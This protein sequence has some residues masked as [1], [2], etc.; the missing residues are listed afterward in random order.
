MAGSAGAEDPSTRV[1]VSSG[2]GV[3]VGDR[4]TQHNKYIHTNIETVVIQ[5]SL[6]AAGP[7][8]PGSVPRVWN[9]PARNPG[10][11]GRDGLLE[12]VRERLLAG[13]RAVVQA[14]HGMGGVGK[15]QL[16]AEYAYRF[17]GT[18]DLAWGVGA[19][20]GGPICDQFAA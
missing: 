7:R 10:F 8:P 13:D 11:T 14:L 20:Q 6:P 5:A 12:A 2:Q 16:A 1:D 9:I 3:Q 4:G 17:A 18:Y 15:T 19:G